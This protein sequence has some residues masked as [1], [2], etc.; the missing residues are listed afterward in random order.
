MCDCGVSVCE[1]VCTVCAGGQGW[2][3]EW[4]GLVSVKPI[5]AGRAGGGRGDSL[6]FSLWLTVSVC[7]CVF[8]KKITVKGKGTKFN[9]SLNS[10]INF[11]FTAQPPNFPF[12]TLTID[13]GSNL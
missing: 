12:Y 10:K 7:V 1:C 9:L 2:G 6:E 8:R 13:I 5:G 11:F 3:R 4:R